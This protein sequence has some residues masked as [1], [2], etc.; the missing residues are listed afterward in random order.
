MCRRVALCPCERPM[1][2]LS[3]QTNLCALFIYLFFGSNMSSSS[4]EKAIDRDFV[5]SLEIISN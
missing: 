3:S 1:L 2:V 5:N 4:E